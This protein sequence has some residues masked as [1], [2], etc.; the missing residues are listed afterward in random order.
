MGKS[1]RNSHTLRDDIPTALIT[2]AS[3]GIGLEIALLLAREG[4]RLILVAR[5]ETRLREI[6]TKCEN[7]NGIPA[8]V[9][10]TDLSKQSAANQ[11][12]MS[13]NWNVDVLVNSAGFPTNG[14]FHESDPLR[15]LELLTVN[16]VSL[17]Y[18][19]RL[20]L[21]G[22]IERGRGRILNVASTAS[23]Q[24]GPRMATYYASKAYVLSFSEALAVELSGTGVTVTAL[25]PGITRTNFYEA[26][27]MMK[28]GL[29][30]GLLPITKPEYVARLGL[31]GLFAGKSVVVPGMI[32]LMIT[33]GVRFLPRIWVA[34]LTNWLNAP[35]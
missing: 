19:T 14:L 17:T 5:N 10:T 28:T 12:K 4:Y 26:G 15:E 29:L 11:I 30:S 27:G 31:R 23:Y 6:A 24:P 2:G 33:I 32:N 9:L 16:I 3:S 22:M 8:Q 7:E 35:R 13:I 20:I 21:P 18:L 25:C 1:E 34:R